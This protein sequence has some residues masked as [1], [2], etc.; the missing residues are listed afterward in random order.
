MQR[1]KTIRYE[2]VTRS[3]GSK[4]LVQI[5]LFDSISVSILS[6]YRKISH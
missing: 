1:I 5:V 3:N 6:S 2:I 4:Q